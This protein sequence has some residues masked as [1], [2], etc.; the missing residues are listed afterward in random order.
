MNAVAGRV[1]HLGVSPALRAAVVGAYRAARLASPV[2]AGPSGEVTH[3]GLSPANRGCVTRCV[4]SPISALTCGNGDVSPLS[5]GGWPVR[6]DAPGNGH[7]DA[8]KTSGVVAGFGSE[9]RHPGV[10]DTRVTDP[11]PEVTHL[12][13]CVTCHPST[14]AIFEPLTY[15]E[16]N[17]D[18]GKDTH[19]VKIREHRDTSAATGATPGATGDTSPRGHTVRLVIDANGIRLYGLPYEQR[20]IVKALP[21]PDRR[22]NGNLRCWVINHTH[23]GTIHSDL[24]DAGYHVQVAD[25]TIGARLARAHTTSPLLRKANR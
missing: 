7:S 23:R 14:K 12:G 18:T 10:G 19:S 5:P 15:T 22:W 17:G 21:R 3:L 20:H 11:T 2:A 4:T 16:S 8:P 25:T 9:M 1:T 13:M 6:G 24:L